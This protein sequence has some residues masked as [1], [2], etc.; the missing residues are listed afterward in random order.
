MYCDGSYVW[1]PNT[2]QE[3]KGGAGAII[4]HQTHVIEYARL[5]LGSLTHSRDAELWALLRGIQLLNTL[6][7]PPNIREV[8]IVSDA[9]LALKQLHRIRPEPGH[10]LTVQWHSAAL[11]FT[12]RYPHITLRVCWGPSKSSGSL[13]AVD[14]LA[15]CSRSTGVSPL[16]SLRTRRMNLRN[17]SLQDWRDYVHI[18]DN[19]PSDYRMS[20]KY[21]VPRRDPPHWLSFPR[22]LQ[23]R[24]AQ[25]LTGRAVT[26]LKQVHEVEYAT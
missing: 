12:Q 19:K 11:Q 23:A 5:G 9:A 17:K 2:V 18:A 24:V 3:S 14:N 25:L 4:V 26:L 13:V 10:N 16:V 1:R 7:P 6:H 20:V 15:K 21:P 8:V 22:K